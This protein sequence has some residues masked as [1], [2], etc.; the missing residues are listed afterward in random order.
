MKCQVFNQREA[1]SVRDESYHGVPG[2]KVACCQKCPYHWR[3]V[4]RAALRMRAR[5]KLKPV[6]VAVAR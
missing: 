3:D 5:M 6:P 1:K 2:V 4:R